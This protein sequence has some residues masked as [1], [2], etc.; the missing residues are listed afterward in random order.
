[1][2]P[3]GDKGAG[4]PQRFQAV[5][6]E[7]ARYLHMQCL[8]ILD[9]HIDVCEPALGMPC[10]HTPT[11]QQ[12]QSRGG[13]AAL[14]LAARQ[15]KSEVQGIFAQSNPKCNKTGHRRCSFYS[16]LTLSRISTAMAITCSFRNSCVRSFI[17]K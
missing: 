6:E 15:C 13:E 12:H 1:M 5:H 3:A 14:L 9:R 11:L 8:T 16:P 2:L 7:G 10:K 4:S 17:Q